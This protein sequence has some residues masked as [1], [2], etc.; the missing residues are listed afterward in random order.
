[1]PKTEKS[2]TVY[3][4]RTDLSGKSGLKIFIGPINFLKKL[5]E[6]FAKKFCYLW[7]CFLYFILQLHDFFAEEK[8]KLFV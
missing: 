3:L 5:Q 1:M 4:V 8:L 2:T 6:I 7:E